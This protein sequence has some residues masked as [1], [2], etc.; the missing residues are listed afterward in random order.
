MSRRPPANLDHSITVYPPKRWRYFCYAIFAIIGL[1]PLTWFRSRLPLLGV[2]SY[3]TLHPSQMFPE[4]NHAWNARLSPG[5]SGFD[6]AS[7]LEYAEVKMADV[8]PI[9]LVQAFI[10]SALSSIAV[11]GMYKA[12]R[13]YLL[14]L[15]ECGTR[16]MGRCST[17]S[18]DVAAMTGAALWVCNP[19]ALSFVWWHITLIEATWA[20]LPWLLVAVLRAP[21]WPRRLTLITGAAL[22]ASGRLTMPEPY[23]PQIIVV[24]VTV[25]IIAFGLA[26]RKRQTAI[27]L[28][29]LFTGLSGGVLTWFLPAVPLLHEI[30]SQA[31]AVGGN[32]L[33]GVGPAVAVS[34]AY[35]TLP[36]VL[37]LTAWFT[38]HVENFGIP[39]N[40][41][42]DQILGMPGSL[43][44]FA[45]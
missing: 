13:L 24:S 39:Y 34:T 42:A 25:A 12:V 37:S 21:L 41:W 5:I 10:L 19:F 36:N 22:G 3:F 18:I 45:L 31:L 40:S 20:M 17:V 1:V 26:A 14:L 27:C 9:W 38:L 11:F 16:L 4:A 7:W 32:A 15:R 43:L 35:A 30:A 29:I 6:N 33:G 28:G 23:L 8:F 2:D 44:R